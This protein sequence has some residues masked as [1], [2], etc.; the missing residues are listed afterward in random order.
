M[1]LMEKCEIGL[2]RME[3]DKNFGKPTETSGLYYKY[4]WLLAGWASYGRV[5]S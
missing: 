1:T 5:D 2:I 3:V 4:R